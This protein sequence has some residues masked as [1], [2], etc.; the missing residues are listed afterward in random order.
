[1][2][3]ATIIQ[4]A[5]AKVVRRM[6]RFLAADEEWLFEQRYEAGLA[7]LES[8][9]PAGQLLDLLAGHKLFWTWWN[10]AWAGRDMELSTRTKVNNVGVMTITLKVGTDMMAGATDF[11]HEPEEFRTYYLAGHS[12]E[13][14]SIQLDPVVLGIIIKSGRTAC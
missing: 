4:N 14:L 2:N 1:M 12:P 9:Y 13:K 6:L 10:N 3:H 7:W 5:D 11:I 8:H